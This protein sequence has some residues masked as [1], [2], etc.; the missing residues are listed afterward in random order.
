MDEPQPS[1][2]LPFPEIAIEKSDLNYSEDAIALD[3]ADRHK[4]ILRYEGYRNRW[5]KWAGMRWEVDHTL[6][7]HAMARKLCREVASTLYKESVERAL[8]ALPPDALKADKDSVRKSAKRLATAITRQLRSAKTVFAVLNLAR[9]DPKLISNVQQWDANAWLLNTPAGTI[10]LKTGTLDKHNVRHYITKL[11]AVS[12]EPGEPTR[13][14]QF[15]NEIFEGNAEMIDYIQRVLGYCITGVTIDHALFYAW[16][17]GQ[18][19]KTTILETIGY[20]LGDYWIE[21]PPQAFIASNES[22]HETEIARMHNVRLVTS[23]ELPQGREWDTSKVKRL[24]GGSTISARFMRQ[25]YFEFEPQFKL[26]MAGNDRPSLKQVDDAIR[27][28][29]HLIPFAYKVPEDRK[30]KDLPLKLEAE[31]ARILQWLIDGCL[32][33]QRMGLQ[34]PTV[35]REAT[36]SYL[37]SEDSLAQ[38]FEECCNVDPQSIS[39]S[40]ELFQSWAHWAKINEEFIGSRKSF[41]QQLTNRAPLF[42]IS[43]FKGREANGFRGVELKNIRPLPSK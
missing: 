2:V 41:S 4:D 42:G 18:N 35:V 19:G 28:R 32:I 9:S 26:L 30:D 7:S 31:G 43:H 5:F 14:L 24:T 34:P 37:T 1:P 36:E 11:C 23:D 10:N 20:I 17:R 29:F 21:S 33:W 3:F 16:G 12:P 39:T 15:L 40:T 38:W 8:K 13:W 25:D 6:S 22:R 27:R